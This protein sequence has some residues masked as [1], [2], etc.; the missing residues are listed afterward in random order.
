MRPRARHR[1]TLVV[2]LAIAAASLAGAAAT[3]PWASGTPAVVAKVATGGGPC[4]EAPGFNAL[5]V[6]NN[7]AGTV[8]RVDPATNAVTATIDVGPGPCGV[9]IGSGSVWVDG[10][11]SNSVIRV[12]P[13]SLKVTKR[14][15]LGD[16]IWDVAYL[17][18][19]AR[20][21]PRTNRVSRRFTIPGFA[22]P[23]NLRFGNGAVWVGELTGHRIWRIDPAKRRLRAIAVRRG[24]AS[25]AVSPSAIW[26]AN[27][28]GNTVSRVN[29]KTLK[30]V[31]TI[32]VG[33]RPQNPAI[34]DDGT[35]YVPNAGSNTVS[36][37]DPASN[38]V[39][40]VTPVGEAPFPAAAAFGDI[41]VPSS[42]G[43]E[44]YRLH[45]Q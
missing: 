20:I 44:V 26:V 42:R 41:W 33:S 4:S 36:R 16:A 28:Q 9:A 2:I 18:F 43:T 12:D 13:V 27:V 5:W 29:P 24:P 22:G 45:T 19:V 40:S 10:Y 25:L 3:R 34:A 35:V 8:S 17:N 1:S 23:A 37:I 11:A 15:R 6:G 38:R 39:I 32:K 21:N 14:I 30:V 31:A 7:L